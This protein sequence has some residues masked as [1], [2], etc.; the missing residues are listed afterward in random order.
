MSKR[1]REIGVLKISKTVDKHAENTLRGLVEY[2]SLQDI[3]MMGVT[4]LAFRRSPVTNEHSTDIYKAV[5][6]N[7]KL[8]SMP[9]TPKR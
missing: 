8:L 5:L 6:T 1:E 2:H 4:N 9:M 7:S 3:F